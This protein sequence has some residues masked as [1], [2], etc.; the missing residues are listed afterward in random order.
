MNKR[1]RGRILA[2]ND[3]STSHMRNALKII[4]HAA[5][6][7]RSDQWNPSNRLKRIEKAIFVAESIV[8][9]K[10]YLD[11]IETKPPARAKERNEVSN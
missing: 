4:F 9:D 1:E 11:S 6:E 7:T 10:D 5:R 8:T 2:L 3:A